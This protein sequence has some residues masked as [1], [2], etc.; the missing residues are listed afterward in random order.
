MAYLADV[1]TAVLDGVVAVL[2]AVATAIAEN[3]TTIGTLIIMGALI[4]LV[5]TTGSRLF[6][7]IS[8]WFRALV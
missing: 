6:R 4:G 3:A 5:I 8:G 1:L 2:S 7:S